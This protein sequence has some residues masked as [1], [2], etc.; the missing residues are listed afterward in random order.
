MAKVIIVYDNGKQE[1]VREVP[2]GYWKGNILFRDDYFATKLWCSEDIK[3][4]MEDLGYKVTPER[5]DDIINYG[6]K[7]W[8][9]NDCNDWEWDCID[10]AIMGCLGD[11]CLGDPDEEEGD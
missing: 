11:G 4:R 9:L 6:G 3:C 1:L 5:I 7:W 10:D 8:G 2:D